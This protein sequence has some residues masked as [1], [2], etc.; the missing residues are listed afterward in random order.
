MYSTSS[1]K[2][3][4]NAFDSTPCHCSGHSLEISTY[5]TFVWGRG[6]LP[7]FLSAKKTHVVFSVFQPPRCFCHWSPRLWSSRVHQCQQFPATFGPWD[8][9]ISRRKPVL[10]TPSNGDRWGEIFT[11][12]ATR[13]I[14]FHMNLTENHLPQVYSQGF[15]SRLECCFYRHKQH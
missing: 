12:C 10:K 14:E 15:I 6:I 3:P 1:H 4:I 9:R 11:K 5:S 2:H 7:H 8:R 13:S